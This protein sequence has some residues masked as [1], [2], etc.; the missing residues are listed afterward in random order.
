MK[1]KWIRNSVL[2]SVVFLMISCKLADLR[3]PEVKQL[4]DNYRSNEQKGRELLNRAIQHQ[5]FDKL[6]E[7]ETYEIILKDRWKGVAGKI[8]NVWPVNNKKI[9][10]RFTPN[11]FDGQLEILEGRKK[12][13]VWGMQ[14]WQVYKLRPGKEV[15][16]K[17]KKRIAFGLAAFHYLFEGPTRLSKAPVI[18]YAGEGSYNN[19]KYDKV[20]VSWG[21]KPDKKYD[22]YV[23]WIE[24]EKGVIELVSYTVRDNFLPSPKNIY[25]TLILSDYRNIDGVLFPFQQTAQLNDPKKNLNHYIHKMQ[26]EKFVMNTFSKDKL[27][28]IKQLKTIGDKKP[29]K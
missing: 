14:S 9:A 2:V 7:A 13:T 24:K 21:V 5:G 12:G 20:F 3:T 27:Y 8:G 19:K 26:I 22:Q 18:R 6:V 16:L 4:D 1:V 15:V 28:P 11:T 29:N 25:A 23:V 17:K 10:L